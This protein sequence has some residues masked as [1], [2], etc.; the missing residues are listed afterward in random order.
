LKSRD[1]R[2]QPVTRPVPPTP[3][4]PIITIDLHR[5]RCPILLC[6]PLSQCLGLDPSGSVVQDGRTARH[7]AEHGRGY[8]PPP[9]G[10]APPLVWSARVQKLSLQPKGA[11][12]GRKDQA[13]P[14]AHIDGPPL[15]AQSLWRGD[16]VTLK[17][18]SVECGSPPLH[19][20]VR[21]G[22]LLA[23]ALCNSG[24]ALPTDGSLLPKK[25]T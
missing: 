5:R 9:R 13:G 2:P 3:P 16:Q 1:V 21:V 18:W 8:G 12:A 11:F 6:S 14:V 25:K 7:R 17:G 24:Y 4:L 15:V 10:G 19:W 20:R 23:A 22:L